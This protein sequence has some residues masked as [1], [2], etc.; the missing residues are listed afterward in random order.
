MA[1]HLGQLRDVF[2]RLK[3]AGLKLKPSRC[4]LLQNR[5]Q[6]LVHVVSGKGIET[7]P[8]KV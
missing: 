1:E 6:Y 7:D 8:E 5:V 4:H 3:N 2:T